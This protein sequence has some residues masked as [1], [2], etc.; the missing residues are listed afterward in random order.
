MD[1]NTLEQ[2]RARREL[3]INCVSGSDR[4]SIMNQ[5]GDMVWNTA[6]FRVINEARGLAP[7]AEEG[8]V[9]LNGLVHRLIN[10]CFL[11]GQ[12]LAI[13]RLTDNYPI[14]GHPRKRDVFSLTS[15]LEDMRDHAHLMTRTNIFAAEGLEYDSGHIRDRCDDYARQRRQEGEKAIMIPPELAWHRL[16][17]RHE[18]IDFFAG[19]SAEHR[20]P[21]D[22]V[23]PVVMT[24]LKEKT[25]AACESIHD[26]VDKFLA[27]A[28]S[29]ESRQAVDPDNFKI[30]LNDLYLAHEAI[31]KVATFVSI[32]LLGG[33][34]FG[35]LATPQYDHL[36]YIDRPLI[37]GDGIAALQEVWRKYGREVRDW[38]NW[39]MDGF[40]Q[41]FGGSL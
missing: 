25:V 39:G 35:G 7:P 15:L 16:E 38:G 32:Y 14:T 26:L 27:H 3:W 17:K 13:R 33:S 5:I 4:H 19:V 8:G 22:S 1:S 30:T 40:Q 9:Q 23:R 20:S 11:D 2:F 21:H 34:S 18:Q 29:P 41:E 10:D 24:R 31:C 36:A 12:M 28:A 6:A 37:A